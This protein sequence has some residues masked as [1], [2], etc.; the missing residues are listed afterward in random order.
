MKTWLKVVLSFLISAICLW[1]VFRHFEWIELKRGFQMASWVW[2]LPSFLAFLLASVL[3]TTRWFVLLSGIVVITP[4]RLFSILNFGFLMNNVLPARMG[5]LARGL[6]VSQIGKA[7]FSSCLATIVIERASDFLGLF[8]LLIIAF[9]L[10]PLKIAFWSTVLI[11][12]I[13]AALFSTLFFFRYSLKLKPKNLLFQKLQMLL[14]QFYL[15]LSAIKTSRKRTLVVLLAI[16]IWLCDAA[17]VFIFSRAFHLDLSFPQAC[18]FLVGLAFG[19]MIPAA[20]GYVGTFE[21]FSQKALSLMNFSESATL[22]FVLTLH[23]FQIALTACFGLTY[24]FFYTQIKPTS[25]LSK[26]VNPI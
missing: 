21:F 14:D 11:T 12:G 4:V 20:P 18:G 1:L 8:F 19:V 16:L 3:R 7:S 9:K 13:L 2:L 22:P 26:T 25:M 6:A 10:L 15:G 23:F 5:E 24:F 17:T